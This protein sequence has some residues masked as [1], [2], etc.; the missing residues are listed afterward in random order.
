MAHGNG[1]SRPQ[2]PQG[3]EQ[4]EPVQ[5]PK[6]QQQQQQH[7][8]FGSSISDFMCHGVV[9]PPVQPGAYQPM[10]MRPIAAQVTDSDSY[11]VQVCSIRAGDN[12]GFV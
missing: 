6:P 2:T 10:A 12:V 4:S 3:P 5:S 9:P 8:A 11:R 1:N 7:F